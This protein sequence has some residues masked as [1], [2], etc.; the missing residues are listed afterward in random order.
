MRA[1]SLLLLA[2]VALSGNAGCSSD[3]FN[4]DPNIF[5]LATVSDPSV[6]V[7]Q[8]AL[9]TAVTGG[10]TMSLHLG[11]R[12][13]DSSDVNLEGFQLKSED[14]NTIVVDALP[15]A[16]EGRKFPITVEPDTD[17]DVKIVIDLGS[18]LLAKDIGQKLCN[19][20]K[21]RYLGSITDS[22]RGG[23]TPVRTDPPVQVTG[24][25]TP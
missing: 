24:C 17:E 8:K 25:T 11:A 6:A 23:S 7:E 10:F 12:A 13:S 3:S 16:A 15:L 19:F 1:H 20:G 5:V 2:A 14:E 22:L 4:T 18:D 21:V 9:G